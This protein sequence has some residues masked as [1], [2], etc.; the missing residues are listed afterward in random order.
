MLPHAR[1]D[2]VSADIYILYTEIHRHISIP[3][4]IHTY[5]HTYIRKQTRWMNKSNQLYAY[6]IYI[7]IY[8]Y[9]YV[10][11]YMYGILV[12][13]KGSATAADT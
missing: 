11:V 1:H 3:R 10:Y 12:Y 9:I 5:M 13:C 2:Q 6:I 7:Y 4:Y 8:V